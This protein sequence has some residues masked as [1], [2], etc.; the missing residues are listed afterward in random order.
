MDLGVVSPAS[1]NH[2][3]L[4]SSHA[5]VEARALVD[6]VAPSAATVLVTGPTGSGKE[7]VAR[8]LHA[9]SPRAAAP[10]VAVN[11]G[12]I[13]R[14]LI[15]AELFGHEAGAFTGAR[16][17]RAGR[18]ESAH[19]GTLFLDEVAELPLDMQVKL[20]RVL[21]TRIV[22]RVGGMFGAPVDVRIVAA[23][24]VDLAAAVAAGSF[25]EDLFFRLDVVRVELPPLAERPG[26][27]A[28]LA[29]HFAARLGADAPRFTA[30]ALDWLARQPWRGNV[31]ELRNLVERAAALHRGVLVDEVL[32]RA[33]KP[34]APRPLGAWLDAPAAAATP[35]ARRRPLPFDTELAAPIDL[36][37]VLSEV[38]Q[39]LI[40]AALS[41]TSG[42][43]AD[44]ARMLGLRR[45]TL[46]EKMRR[47]NIQRMTA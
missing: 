23:T 10:F 44:S 26:D 37:S 8:R 5:I 17:A 30:G 14:E 2:D 12:A 18:F 16:R 6:R 40:E 27:I 34:P 33:L 42:I 22:E 3:L 13:P 4:G 9:M 28:L 1:H 35:P 11:C 25:R 47:L 19:R 20:L 31:R 29:E 15:E 38:E 36:Q 46:V 7:V 39:S 24:N 41:R 21:E 43:V 45:T 32:V